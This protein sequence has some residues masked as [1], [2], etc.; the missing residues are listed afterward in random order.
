MTSVEK[1]QFRV[2]RLMLSKLLDVVRT[3]GMARSTAVVPGRRPMYSLESDPSWLWTPTMIFPG[4]GK[5]L[6]VR[7]KSN[8]R[9]IL[10][11]LCS[12][13]T[14]VS[15][16]FQGRH[17]LKEGL[18]RGDRNKVVPSGGLC[19]NRGLCTGLCYHLNNCQISG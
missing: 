7:C 14:S 9:S 2:P 15:Y 5:V 18:I 11:C 6:S 8:T 10:L 4:P 16:I 12:F 3:N 19:I 13:M 17:V 1:R